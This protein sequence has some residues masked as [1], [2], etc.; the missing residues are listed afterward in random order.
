MSIFKV[1]LPPVDFKPEL[2]NNLLQERGT[3]VIWE[4]AAICACVRADTTTGKTSFS[5]GTCYQGNVYIDPQTILGV[6]TNVTGQRNAIVYGELALGGIYLT[7]RGDYRVGQNDRI[8]LKDSSTRYAELKPSMPT[9]RV[10][11]ASAGGDTTLFTDSTR[12]FPVE[13]GKPM[14]AVLNNNIFTYTGR[15][16]TAP[17]S[18]TGVVGLPP[19]NIG[20]VITS[21]GVTLRYQPL[22]IYDIRTND[23]NTFT[24]GNDCEIIGVRTLRWKNKDTMPVNPVT[25][26]YESYPVYI[27]DQISH[28]YRDQLL[29][30]G[31]TSPTLARLPIA[32]IC[33]KDVVNGR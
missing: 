15:T 14:Y 19:C 8:T 20:D 17:Y 30:L 21:M 10:K 32:L 18:L 29:K 3:N 24:I 22:N 9:I 26:L 27:V 6:V 11:V 2:F 31:Y 28:E 33:R 16:V 13:D 4:K 12:L 1:N 5:C 7:V 25:I 23:V